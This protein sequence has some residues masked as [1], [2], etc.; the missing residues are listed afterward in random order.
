MAM[1][2]VVVLAIVA[3][4]VY[5]QVRPGLQSAPVASSPGMP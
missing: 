5:V 4:G 2:A 1:L 3:S